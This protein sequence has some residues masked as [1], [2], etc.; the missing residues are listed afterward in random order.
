[1]SIKSHG[2]R[3]IIIDWYRALYVILGYILFLRFIITSRDDFSINMEFYTTTIVL[4]IYNTLEK[5]K[6]ENDEIGSE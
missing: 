5:H 3:Y 1:M 4:L 2:I 6:K